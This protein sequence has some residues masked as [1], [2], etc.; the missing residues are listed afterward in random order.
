VE[1]AHAKN[2][3][4]PNVRGHRTV[5][6]TRRPGAWLWPGL[7]LLGWIAVV[8]VNG[9]ANA[10]PFNGQTTGEVINKDPIFFQPDGWVFAIWGG[11]YLLLGAFVVYGLVPA[12][13]HNPRLQRISPLFL[14]TCLANAVWLVFWHEERFGLSMLVMTTL[15]L[16]L[17]GIYS[18]LRAGDAEP[19]RGERLLLWAPFS[20]Y[21]AWISIATIANAATWLDRSGWDGGPI[22]PPT[23]A[24]IMVAAGTLLATTVVVRHHDPA[25]PLVFLWA[26]LGIATR[27]WNASLLVG[28]VAIASATAAAALVV[29]AASIAFD[30]HD[31]GVRS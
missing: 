10:L 4:H 31:E 20:V 2:I 12:G 8:V 24:A 13:R 26:Y 1:D 9:L 19:S 5:E 22:S 17:I 3:N 29:L 27:Q 21:L 16:A 18:L 25:F 15:L 6:R 11:I 14:L 7:N 30:R 28:I 23:W